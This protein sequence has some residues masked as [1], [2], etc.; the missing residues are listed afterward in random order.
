MPPKDQLF[1]RPGPVAMN[2][3]SSPTDEHL[4]RCWRQQYC[5]GCLSQDKCS[6]CPFTQS[7]VPN[8]YST[9]LLAPAY[10]ENICPHWAERW[11]IRTHPFGCQVSTITSLASIISIVSTLVFVL[12][13]WLSLWAIRRL[14]K[15]H[16]EQESGWWKVWTSGSGEESRLRVRQPRANRPQEQEPLLRT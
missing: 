2:E 3:T 4:L 11:E 9:Q 15:Y 16:G 12:L 14:R 10:D 5:G 8:D 6:W 1:L 13:V 7:C